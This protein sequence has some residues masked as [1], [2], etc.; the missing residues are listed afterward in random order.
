MTYEVFFLVD[1]MA[2]GMFFIGI[3]VGMYLP[4]LPEPLG[5]LNPYLGIAFLVVAVALMIK[6]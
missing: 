1:K 4:A 6:G 2:V 3:S 5:M